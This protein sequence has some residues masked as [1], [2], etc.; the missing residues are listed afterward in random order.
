MSGFTGSH[1]PLLANYFEFT[2]NR[3]SNLSYF[4]QTVNLPGIVT[5][6]EQQP[7]TFGLPVQIPIGNFR[8]ENLQITFKVD[9]DLK[10]WLEIWNWLKGIGNLDQSC[11]SDVLPYS[12]GGSGLGKTTS[13]GALLLTN[14]SFK[15][16]FRINF[17]NLF[18]V[19]IS[20]LLF[21]STLPESSEVVA[22]AEFAFTGYSVERVV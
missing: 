13:N 8:F 12:P 6:V 4:C 9:E 14:S 21:S 1:N 3:V 16:K 18:P 7:T 19:S 20:G 2:L 15:P 10:N 5:G 11:S 17:K 22:T